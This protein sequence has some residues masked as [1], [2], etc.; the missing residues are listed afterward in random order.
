MILTFLFLLGLVVGSFINSIV[1]RVETGESVWFI[2]GSKTS[3]P[4]PKRSEDEGSP[5]FFAPRA[6]NDDKSRTYHLTRSHCPYCKKELRWFELIPILSFVIQKGRCR[7][8]GRK[9]SL[10]YPLVELST[11]I[12]FLVIFNF[13]F[14]IFN[15]FSILN[16]QFI[17]LLTINYQQL[18]ISNFIAIIYLL[19]ITSF[20]I[21]IFLSD[22]KYY[23]IPDKI[24]YPAIGIAFVYNLFQV[25]QP[26][27]LENL[28]G[29]AS[30]KFLLNPLSAAFLA[31]GFFL[32]LVL[33]SGGRWM[34]LGDAKLGFFMGLV[35]GLANILV[36]LMLAFTL[37]ALI[38]I[39][40]ILIKKKTLKSEIPFG[41][42]LTFSTFI[43]MI[44][45]Q[46][47]VEW[48]WILLNG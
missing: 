42:F 3:H 27:F 41:T 1:Y 6:K 36:A 18:T 31:G 47:M 44:F 43:V 8:C 20:L 16:F 26:K 29:Q 2:G 34:G 46:K 19:L 39:A 28:G 17:N 37:G 23:I 15:Q 24:I 21:I 13:Q 4:E 9:I 40:L 45:G 22:L 7:S 33:A 11:G 35:L 38:G 25:S 5:S 14:S 32:A 30:F 10:Q 12:L 48:Y